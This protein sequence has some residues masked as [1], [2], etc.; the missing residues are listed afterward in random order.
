MWH[1]ERV[2]EGTRRR[3]TRV[4]G[5]VAGL[6]VA[7]AGAVL[8]L[9][10]PAAA[11]ASSVVVTTSMLGSAVEEL[12]PAAAG[13]EVVRLLPPGACPG[14]FDLSPRA[15][16]ALRSASVIVRHPYQ[17]V[18]ESKLRDLGVSDAR[19][20]VAGPGDSLLVPAHY[21]ALVAE[22][23]DVV[24]QETGRRAPELDAAV[25]SVRRRMT[26]LEGEIRR[27]PS[28]WRGAKVIASSMQAEFSRW[29]GLDVV[30]ELG[31]TEDVAPR[32]LEGLLQLH[33]DLVVANL[34][35]GAQAATGLA[36]RLGV[37][38]AV[39]SNF[40]DAEGYGTGYEELVR[41]DLQRLDAAW[42]AR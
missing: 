28:P 6:A 7:A 4:A 32:E 34:Q 16:P 36:Q 12:G 2:I 39:L 38:V 19:V 29:L 40:P 18:L 8:W 22:V 41:S 35:E 27:R 31:R 26:D 14:H 37:P 9:G 25:A 3:T 5:A 15:L 13:L 20:V 24:E 23:A 30:G 11:G 33:P 1:S 42:N 21:A 17:G 10:A